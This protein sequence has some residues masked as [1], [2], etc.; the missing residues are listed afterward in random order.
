MSRLKSKKKKVDKR[1]LLVAVLAGLMALALLLP[2]LGSV[3]LSAGAVTQEELKQQIAGLKGSAT[4]VASQK[5]ELEARLRAIQDD[6]A[7]AMEQRELLIQQLSAI[8]GEIANTQSQIDT[9]HSLIAEQETALAEAQAREEAAEQRFRARARAME[10]GGDI[11]Y[12]SVLFQAD[13]FTDL[14]DRLAMVDEIVAYDNSVVEEL[15]LAREKVESTLADLR[16]TEAGLEEQRKLLDAQRFEQETKV[17]QVE[18]VL[19]VLKRDEANAQALHEAAEADLKQQEAVIAQKEREYK[20]MV[21]ASHKKAAFTTGSGY[22]YPLSSAYTRISSGF[23]WRNCPFHGRE[24]HNGM[25]L[26]APSGTSIYAVQG[27]VV[28]ISSY[29]PASYGNYVMIDHGNGQTTMYAHMSSRAVKA[30]DAVKQGQT[31]GYVG[32]TGSST[33][34]HLHLEWKVDGVR[35]DPKGMFPGV[36]FTGDLV[37]S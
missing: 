26:P 3:F 8:E 36:S 14:L 4:N 30:G 34:P 13:S 25:D 12:L 32:S 5:Q 7:R 28:I 6:K 20:A 19:D 22:A 1:R 15:A 10:E 31:I 33:G 21:E 29:A 27:G 17:S 9:Y 35:R 16:E 23:K 2:L 11:S 18:S 37:S 24:H